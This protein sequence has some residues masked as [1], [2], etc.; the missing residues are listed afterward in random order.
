ME[1]E[2]EKTEMDRNWGNWELYTQKK[3]PQLGTQKLSIVWITM[4]IT[5]V[6]R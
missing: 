4:E 3:N 5:R 6:G 1:Q 2:V